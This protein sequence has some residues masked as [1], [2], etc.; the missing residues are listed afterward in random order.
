MTSMVASKVVD[1]SALLKVVWMSLALGTGVTG[2]FSL[3]ILGATR[4]AE[5]RSDDRPL[6]AGAFAVLALA[7]LA[8]VAAAV[9]FGIIVMTSK[10]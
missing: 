2:A 1:V 10:D 6:A 5:L 7:G 3:A 8:V 4:F 9:V